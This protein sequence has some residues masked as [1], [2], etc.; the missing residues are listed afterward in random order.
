MGASSNS[1]VG[2]DART[3]FAELE[4][5]RRGMTPARRAAGLWRP[6]QILVRSA[7]GTTAMT[8][9]PG[10]Q[11]SLAVLSLLLVLVFAGA[12][13]WAVGSRQEVA[14]AARGL[15]W[16]TAV[17]RQADSQALESGE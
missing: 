16:S 5:L 2:R 11:K 15:A 3:A 10:R 7:T 13:G 1:R 9:G 12:I 14:K 17:A 8:L 4:A 6:R